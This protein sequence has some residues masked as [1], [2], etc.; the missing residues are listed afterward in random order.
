[1]TYL[2]RR[3]KQPGSQRAGRAQAQARRAPDLARE[4]LVFTRGRLNPEGLKVGNPGAIR[5]FS[6]HPQMLMWTPV[7]LL[8]L[9]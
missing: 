7:E 2:S 1:M 8:N 3:A 9:G 5:Y 4:S 6:L